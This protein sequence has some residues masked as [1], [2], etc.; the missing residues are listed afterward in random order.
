M[1][2]VYIEGLRK[3]MN[4][5]KKVYHCIGRNVRKWLVLEVVFQSLELVQEMLFTL[6]SILIAW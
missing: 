5:E 6:D 3:T 2:G 4:S 1:T